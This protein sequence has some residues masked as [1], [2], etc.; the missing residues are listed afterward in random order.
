MSKNI[1][2]YFI[3]LL[4]LTLGSCSADITPEVE[5][6]GTKANGKLRLIIDKNDMTRGAIDSSSFEEGDSVF[7]V[8]RTYVNHEN[9]VHRVLTGS[10]KLQNG[11]W[12]ISNKITDALSKIEWTS[13]QVGVYYPYNII[14]KSYSGPNDIVVEDFLKEQADILRGQSG[15]VSGNNP[16]VNITCNHMTTRLTF[17]LKNNSETSVKVN[18]ISIETEGEVP[19]LK[20][21]YEIGSDHFNNKYPYDNFIREFSNSCDIE[22]KPGEISNLDFLLPSTRYIVKEM[23]SRIKS[24][25]ISPTILNFTLY[26]NGQPVHFNLNAQEWNDGSQYIYPVTLFRK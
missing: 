19:M 10:A 21:V 11:E 18:E 25:G 5:Y 9:L 15:G 7:V 1:I 14:A 23:Q 3:S 13:V 20:N 6:S 16:T 26:I 12:E 2:Y 24:E 4:T 17:A 8:M 22:I